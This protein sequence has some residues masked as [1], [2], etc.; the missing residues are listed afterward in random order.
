MFIKMKKFFSLIALVG[1]FAA[2]EPE[3]VLT[4]FE[5]NDAVATVNVKVVDVLTGDDVTSVA[6]ITSTKGTVEGA[7]VKVTG[8]P[9]IQA[10]DITIT[11]S[12]NGFS[13]SMPVSLN[14]ILAGGKASYSIVIVVGNVVDDYEYSCVQ[15]GN[16]KKYLI[17]TSYLGKAQHYYS[18]DGLEY[19]VMNPT[20]F[21]LKGNVTYEGI[22]GQ[23][24]AN[25]KPVAGFETVSKFYADGYHDRMY[26]YD[27]DFDIVVSAYSWY[28]AYSQY[29]VVV[30]PFAVQATKDGKSQVVATFDVNLYGTQV[31]YKEIAIPYGYHGHGHYVQGHGHTHGHGA[32]ANAGGGIIV[33]E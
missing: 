13:S 4:A 15:A 19:W 2:C 18:H 26:T 7:V 28:T 31:G 5:V 11:A 29:Y 8:D 17:A 20:E 27:D 33:A 25:Y 14:Y 21:L 6:T 3:Q 9:A 10:Q 12:Y 30:Y 16:G 32:D 23:V 1:L 22:E 24:V